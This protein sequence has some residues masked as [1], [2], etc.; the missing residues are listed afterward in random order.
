M[1][2]DIQK[3]WDK[4][5]EEWISIIDTNAIESRKFTNPAILQTLKKL[6][7]STILD[8]GCGEG[9]LTRE[10]TAMGKIAL[11]IDGTEKLIERAKTKGTEVY[12]QMKY[13]DITQ[14]TVI[15]DSLFDV[16]V[17]NFS[18]YQET[19]M[20]TLLL[21]IQNSLHTEGNIII[22]TLH[23]YF[24]LEHGNGYCSQWF[25]DSWKGLPG[26]FKDGHSW[27]ARTFA[28]WITVFEHAGLRTVEVREVTNDNKQ[29][30]SIIYT[31]KPC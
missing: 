16:I 11:G 26:Q 12:R 27:F 30:I 24:I 19:G 1:N 18:L 14:H 17:F 28:D 8:C 13:E 23:P 7:G 4:N 3:S 10:M 9:W 5:A 15:D 21:N 29:P 6:K 25:G 31:L 22:Q 20:G 2:T